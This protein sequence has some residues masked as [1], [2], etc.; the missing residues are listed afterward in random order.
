MNGDRTAHAAGYRQRGPALNASRDGPRRAATG[1]GGSKGVRDAADIRSFE[2]PRGD[3]RWPTRHDRSH[4][5][6]RAARAPGAGVR[7][8]LASLLASLLAG[9]LAPAPSGA[10]QL[11]LPDTPLFVPGS[12]T[13]L[14]Q[15]VVQRDNNLF[16]EAYPSW[17]D[18]DGDGE[19][20]LRYDP[21]S[22]DY[23]GYFESSFCYRSAND[24]LE[25]VANAQDKKCTSAGAGDAWSG[26]FLNYLTMTRMDVMLRA[27]HG[28]TRLVD[29]A[30]DTVLRRAFVPWDNHTWGIEYTSGSVDGYRIE[31]YS[32]LEQP[33]SGRR[34]H[35]ATNNEPE[36]NDV[37]YLRVREDEKDRIWDWIEKERTQGDGDADL[38]VVLDVRACKAGFLETAC[39]QYPN[40]NHKPV[41][42]LHEYGENDSMYFGLVTGSYE[43]NIQGGVV[44]RN[45]GDFG[46]AEVDPDTG[47]FLPVKGI[48]RT[49]DAL[50]I[51]NDYRNS[52]VQN[53]CGWIPDRAF[54][55]G[56]C[57]AWGNPVAEMMYEGLR[58]YAGESA[59]TP[60]FHTTG[61]MDAT[62]GLEAPDWEDPY[63]ADNPWPQCTAAYQLVVSDPS[64]S[65]DGDQLPG[66][67]FSGFTDSSLGNLHVG[68]LADAISS[69]E[70]ALPGL[71]F[72]G[73]ADGV[74]DGSPSPK[75]VTSFRTIRGQAPEAPHRQ[76]SYYA[77]SVAWH[78]HATDLNADVPGT[79][80]VGNFTLALG[81]PLPT[82]D[83]EVGEREIS[84]APFAKTVGG[85]YYG[86]GPAT[87]YAPTDAIVGF[88]IEELGPTSGSYRVSFEDM[89]QG[90]DN[91]MDALA[92]YT[93]EVKGNGTVVMEVE[94]MQASGC[95]IQHLG[96]TVSGSDADGVY[97]VVRDADTKDKMLNYK[98]KKDKDKDKE[99]KEREKE[100]KEQEK[101]REKEE[102]ER[103]KQKE[104][105]EKDKNEN[106]NK[107]EN[108]KYDDGADHTDA[109]N[110]EIAEGK[111]GGDVDFVLDVPPGERPGGNWNDDEPLPLDSRI[112]FRPSSD[113]AAESLKSPLWYAAK[114]GG[115]QDRNRDGVPQTGEWDSDGDGDPD[116]YFPVT[117]PSKMVETL[118]NVFDAIAEMSATAGAVGVT[119]SSLN[120][121]SRVYETSFRS[122][123]WTGALASHDIA[124]D[125]TVSRT[126]DW[127]ASDALTEQIEDGEREILTWNPTAERGVAFRWPDN[128]YTPDPDEI[129]FS[130]VAALSKS[131]VDG[132]YDYS[133][134]DGRNRV[135]WLRGETIDGMRGRAGPLGDIVHSSPALV[136]PPVYRYRDDWGED[137]PESAKP[138]SDFGREHSD[139]DRVVYVGANDG[140]LH[141]FDA[142]SLT[143]T[144]W[145]AGT[146]EERFAY[147]PGA[148][149]DELPELTVESYSHR[150]YV[151]ATPS[152]GDAFIDG[153]WASV[154]VGGLG[155][156]G[157]AVYALD[158]TD[159]DRIDEDAA[160]DAVLWEFTDDDDADLGYTFHS[161][162]IVRLRDGR[163]AAVFGNGYNAGANDGRPSPTGEASLF[164]VDLETGNLTAKLSTG[165]GSPSRPN[166]LGP[167][168]A[169]D[170]DNDDVVDVVYA[171]DL[172][173]NVWKFDLHSERAA[174]WSAL[175]RERIF[176]TVDEAG[177]PAPITTSIAVGRH[178]TGEGVLLFVGTGKY[179]EPRD[180]APR[181]A[182]NRIWGLWD[183]DPLVWEDLKR[184]YDRGEFLEQEITSQT[185]R[186]LD[187]D[188]D[189]ATDTPVVVRE[190]TRRAID[191]DV[192]SGWYL[193]LSH[194]V[195]LGEQVIAAPQLRESRL[196]VSTQTPAGDECRP[197]QTGW[198]MLLDA[199]SGAMP[200][201]GLDLDGDG[202]FSADEAVSGVRD[203]GN[204]MAPATVVSAGTDDVL[205]SSDAG[206]GGTDSSALDALTQ[207][208]RV[209]WR[210][211]EP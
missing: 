9:A 11:N 194:T 14:V 17:E 179:L 159:P 82:I 161:P 141:A 112:V 57:R 207:T 101:E 165:V 193:D 170:L 211:L 37:P 63:A 84:F 28:G 92:R 175:N 118:R 148:V 45:I 119:G 36:R 178:P 115:F 52:T 41:G 140:M 156:G 104:K 77:P 31:D 50:R 106:K 99:E 69:H 167:P 68:D 150:Y 138:Y 96:Y 191:W 168:T 111:N 108:E 97:L 187:T 80:N 132:Q 75:L 131:P 195:H 120:A 39:R 130:Q 154:V 94:S 71:K 10:A 13:A 171:G 100:R 176:R 166:A 124:P 61:G 21:E 162:L 199:A 122:G 46:D 163:W 160:E 109:E 173:G 147:V 183:R 204:P 139:R 62:L 60:S 205:L 35:L 49:L 192:H 2:D 172:R 116:N 201:T 114:W 137:E 144:G 133:G 85:C 32:P 22:I 169:V 4:D 89:E 113:P 184:R 3:G 202:T 209:S 197:T 48:V 155:R 129:D 200:D 134:T 186:Q 64:P 76:G 43:N 25:A 8:A 24:V 174:D 142:G 181:T 7:L 87:D 30:E 123:V 143:E 126:A 95:L 16:F 90:A 54:R 83:V 149:Y 180:Q 86:D 55:N 27:L 26:D 88:A 136:G 65:F 78:G 67:H 74:A 53:D 135:S 203:A 93:Y 190:S 157:Q 196:I 81:S 59:P 73:E 206:G 20:D 185:T 19:V 15:L 1:P 198:T 102:K 47:A 12:K 40:G 34:H 18:I 145:S 42:L 70:D 33:K 188:G 128:P 146:G 56:E 210:E 103:E 110:D 91:D 72:I 177:T 127:Q 152:A 125:G 117:E 158:V 121:G 107:N 164:V 23:Y 98:G 153:D 151:D 29:T 182:R 44:R 38:D 58:H 105:E 189:G 6:P 208:G 51:P 79:Q 66:S 5:A